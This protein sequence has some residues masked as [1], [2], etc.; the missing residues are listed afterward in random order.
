METSDKSEENQVC[1]LKRGNGKLTETYT[2]VC[3]H[4]E[5]KTLVQNLKSKQKNKL[6]LTVE[7]YKN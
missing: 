4:Q 5:S 2:K 3:Y 6:C 7:F 1:L